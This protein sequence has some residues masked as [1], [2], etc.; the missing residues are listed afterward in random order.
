LDGKASHDP[1]G[2][3]ILG[4]SWTQLASNGGVTVP[5]AAAGTATPT[6]TAPLLPD[7]KPVMLIFSLRVIDSDGGAVSSNPALAYI[8]VKPEAANGPSSNSGGPGGINQQTIPI[9]PNTGNTV[10]V[11]RPR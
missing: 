1:D 3:R 10:L 5:L 6:F 2:G 7:G 8:V 9:I 11:P 4:Y